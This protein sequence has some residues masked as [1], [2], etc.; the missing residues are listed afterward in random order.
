MG[1]LEWFILE[2][3][4]GLRA[5]EPEW[6][7]LALSIAE[8]SIFHSPEWIQTWWAHF[9]AGRR[10]HLAGARRDGRLVALAPL[11]T[12]RGRGGIRV[13]EFLG[14]E[15]ADLAG[16]LLAPGEEALAPLLARFVLEQPGWHLTDL[17]CLAAGSGSAEALGSALR[18]GRARHE[19]STLTINPILDLRPDDWDA[20]A[21]RSMLKDLARQRRVLG[22]QGKL[23]LVFPNDLD[24]VEAAL[25]ELRALHGAR[26]SG[27]GELSRLQLPD[28][29][30]WVRAIAREA[31]R[32][33]WLYLPRL[34]LGSQ[35]IAV[36]LYFLYERRLFYWMGGHDPAFA[37]H[38]PNLLV[39][40]AVVEDLRV[41]RAADVLDFGRG[42]EWYKL[43]WTQAS[44]TLQR[45]MA[46]RGVRGSAAHVWRGRIRPWAWAHPEWSRPVRRFRRAVR[47]LA[48][49]AR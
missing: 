48:A 11:C 43:R 7:Q 46:W 14:S 26:W 12:K 1:R 29:W 40:L 33:G 49:R 16:F 19:V 22:R 21:S 6:R 17:W 35:L 38:S 44:V 42:D 4:A 25:A 27:Q 41:T 24:E 13:R 45:V 34:V 18:S 20:G 30:E 9:G 8:P 47:R 23:A 36:G 5:L 28:Y 31:W 39:T 15:E 10:L 3:D 32:Q 2:D 37:R